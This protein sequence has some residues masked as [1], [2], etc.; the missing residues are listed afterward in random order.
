MLRSTESPTSLAGIP[1]FPTTQ[2]SVVLDA[3]RQDSPTASRALEDFCRAYWYPLYAYARQQGFG[4]HEA[5]DLTQS[6]FMHCLKND[7]L[8]TV[9]PAK[10]RFRTFMRVAMRNHLSHAREHAGALRRGGGL[11]TESLDEDGIERRFLNEANHLGSPHQEFDRRWALAVLDAALTRLRLEYEEAGK[12]S[13]FEV[14]KPF[15]E[16][17]TEQG[18]CQAA[19]QRA[20]LRPI[21]ELQPRRSGNVIQHNSNRYRSRIQHFRVR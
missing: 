20:G 14:L 11:E 10:G 15:L 2:W 13:I 7:M 21:R 4:P 12:S 5:Q 18:E 3:A 9:H 8:S 6:F 1:I 16:S 19:A 17:A